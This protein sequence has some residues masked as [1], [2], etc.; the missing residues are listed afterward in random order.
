MTTSPQGRPAAGG[1]LKD[2]GCK[3]QSH[4]QADP[5][6]GPCPR[7][8]RPRCTA[9]AK[10]RPGERCR[11]NPHPG[12]TICTNHGLTA[13]GREA[14]AQ[15]V[16]EEAAEKA[17]RDQ[18]L[19]PGLATVTPIKDPVA[20]LARLAGAVEHM[21]NVAGTRVNELTGIAGGESMTQLRAEVALLEKLIAR[22]DSLLTNM[23]RLNLGQR[24]VEIEEWQG[25]MLGHALVAALA[26][27][28]ELEAPMRD[29]V[30][31]GVLGKLG[32][33]PEVL[34]LEGPDGVPA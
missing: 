3:P 13:A 24:Q 18:D 28:G 31:R 4:G 9:A 27:I 30:I 20:A 11:K 17:L 2:T 16:A 10:T 33:A 1:S 7:C 5:G 29:R 22:S 21:T 14:A 34:E 23:A 26:E 25:Q 8:S 32:W 19:W 15:R 6:G 12:A